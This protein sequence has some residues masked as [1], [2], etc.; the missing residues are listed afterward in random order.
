MPNGRSPEAATARTRNAP[1]GARDGS[2]APS[3]AAPSTPAPTPT[4]DRTA[5][6]SP[7]MK[8][9][10]EHRRHSTRSGG[11]GLRHL[12]FRDLAQHPDPRNPAPPA[13]DRRPPRDPPTVGG[14]RS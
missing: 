12:W 9:M 3:A 1:R 2:R 11:E 8:G 5:P 4:V 13:P 7:L 6:L 10:H 14:G